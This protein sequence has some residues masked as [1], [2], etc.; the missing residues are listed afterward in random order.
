MGMF[1]FLRFPFTS[2]AA[3]LF[4]ASVF[5]L[6]LF[7]GFTGVFLD[8]VFQSTLIG[9]EKARLRSH[10]YL[11]FSAAELNERPLKKAD[12]NKLQMP[13][14]LI[15]S[16]FERINSGLYAYIF[17]EKKELIW[18][19]NSAAL[20]TPPNYDSVAAKFKVGEISDT[21]IVLNGER[22]FV[23][24]YDVLW[25]DSKKKEHPFRFVVVHDSED[26]VEQ[27]R[28]YR[29]QLLQWLSAVGI[30]LLL[31]QTTVVRWGL[32]PLRKL[33]IALNAMHSGESRDI[34]GDHPYEL[35]EV[36]VSLNQVLAREQ[37]LRQRYRNSLSDL[38]HSLKTPLA[39]LQ[40]RLNHESP[41]TELQS[42]VQEQT[43][44]MNQVVTYQLQRAVA[45][46]QQGST[47]RVAL[48]PVVQR[49]V[50]ALQKVYAQKSIQCTLQLDEHIQ[51]A[52]DEQD[53]MEFAGNII[54]N[55]FKYGHK[56]V[57]IS[58][59]VKQDTVFNKTGAPRYFILSVADDGPGIPADE[60][61][62][63]SER[64]HR[65]DTSIPGQ[66]IGLAVAAD[67]IGSYDGKISIQTSQW[68]GAE[69]NIQLPIASF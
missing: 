36:V 4:F 10:I 1:H 17:D 16:E 35:E 6:P 61:E 51:F 24:H 29:N 19:S 47:S 28:H 57:S 20:Q 27:K 45:S 54:E 63:I 34:E 33:A 22:S 30:L 37:G 7:L 3:R 12:K 26:F 18:S 48:A 40:S 50:N 21:N 59:Y 11:L 8:R 13:P 25:E 43:Q 32:Q 9:A 46:Q 68:N 52:G 67:I 49:L 44:R 41:D 2:I 66:G 39:V 56:R 53:L 42:L 15:D 69:F 5:I 64:G 60:R 65:L 58:T 62:R 38:A 31:A 14:A 23:A 55:A